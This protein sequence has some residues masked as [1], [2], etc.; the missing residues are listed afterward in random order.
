[1]PS[2]AQV[3]Q[4]IARDPTLTYTP[5]TEGGVPIER[6]YPAFEYPG[7]P[8]KPQY[9]KAARTAKARVLARWLNVGK[10]SHEDALRMGAEDWLLAAK[11]AGVNPPSAESVAQALAELKKLQGIE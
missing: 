7:G 4:E 2:P 10:V 3:R 9:A 5:K 1:M 11:G 8:V 6:P